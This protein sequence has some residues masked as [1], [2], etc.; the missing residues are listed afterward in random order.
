MLSLPG[1]KDGDFSLYSEAVLLGLKDYPTYYEK[2]GDRAAYMAGVNLPTFGILDRLSAEIEFSPS[3]IPNTTDG[4]QIR[5][6]AVPIMS[7][8]AKPVRRDDW[9]WTVYA[10]KQ[11][12]RTVSLSAQV[13]SDHIRVPNEFGTQNDLTFLPQGNH[14]Y[15][16]LKLGYSL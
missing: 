5:R 9:K 2:P 1:L 11:L 10:H 7:F 8:P 14:W 15:W 12:H 4:P 13:A 3:P 16:V 6:I